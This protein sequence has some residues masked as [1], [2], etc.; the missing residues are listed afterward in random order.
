MGLERFIDKILGRPG[1]FDVD[2]VTSVLRGRSQPSRT[3][4]FR[5]FNSPP[6]QSSTA[7][8]EPALAS[9]ESSTE[10]KRGPK[11]KRKRTAAPAPDRF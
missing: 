7:A 1:A 10:A 6:V 3:E 11:T 9:N 8:E 2:A 5:G 4:G